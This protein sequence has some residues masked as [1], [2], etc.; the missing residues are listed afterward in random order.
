[1]SFSTDHV[2]GYGFE[3]SFAGEDFDSKKFFDFL[4]NHSETIKS[5]YDGEKI[6]KFIK[7]KNPDLDKFCEEFA[8]RQ[9]LEGGY[10]TARNIVADI[11]NKETGL[12]FSN[13]L[14]MNSDD[15]FVMLTE[16]MPWLLNEKERNVTEKELNDI[17]VKYMT[18][19]GLPTEENFEG[20]LIGM[21]KV[22]YFG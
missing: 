14:D 2:Y 11:M 22:E 15:E 6:L 10:N 3:I 16:C 4:K 1:M 19:I 18:E 20:Q 5:L 17:C 8:D 12:R 21:Q 9:G 7:A 13:Q